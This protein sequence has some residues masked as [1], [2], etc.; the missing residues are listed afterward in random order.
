[1][2]TFKGSIEE[3]MKSLPSDMDDAALSLRAFSRAVYQ[4]TI[5]R[6]LQARLFFVPLSAPPD[7]DRREEI[8]QHITGLHAIFESR[9]REA[10][11]RASSGTISM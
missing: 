5:S 3:I 2:D 7:M 1:L 11:S 6:P 4:Q 9:S 10:S 8:Q